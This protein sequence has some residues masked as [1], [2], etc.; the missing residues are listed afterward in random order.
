MRD[1]VKKTPEQKLADVNRWMS[2]EVSAARVMLEC[3]KGNPIG[4]SVDIRTL[5]QKLKDDCQAIDRGQ[6]Q[7][8][9]RMLI[10]QADALQTLF[11]KLTVMA[12]N[13]EYLS[14]L[15]AYLKLGLRAQNQSRMTLETLGS[16]K[17]P[18]LIVAKQANIA[19]GHQQINNARPCEECQNAPNELL[20]KTHGE[21]LDTGTQK[22]TGGANSDLAP[23]G[24]INGTSDH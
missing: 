5:I 7:K 2:P 3:E 20:E 13:S 8:A 16:L 10:N 23:V 14:Q 9:E 24:A 1:K 4:D 11:T 21:W 17:N 12:M 15:E 18:P 6:L 22:T 19:S